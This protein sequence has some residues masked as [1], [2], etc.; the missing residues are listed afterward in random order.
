MIFLK[1][2]RMKRISIFAAIALA[3]VAFSGCATYDKVST[4]MKSAYAKVTDRWRDSVEV[5]V[6]NTSENVFLTPILAVGHG[7]RESAMFNFGAPASEQLQAVAEGGLISAMAQ[8]FEGAEIVT[9]PAEGLLGPGESVTFELGVGNGRMSL[10]AMILP[11]N[12]GFVALDNVVL[13]PGTQSLYAIDA[14]T[15]AND[16]AITGGGSPNTPG[17]PADPSDTADAGATGISGAK[18]EGAVQRHPGIQGG[19]GSALNPEKHG[20]SGPIAEVTVAIN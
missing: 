20:W 3:S 8:T 14:G 9:N 15:E 13:R 7:E 1:G 2:F 19:E 18:A 17:I 16:E 5:T 6:T 12:D 4:K 10:I 11:T